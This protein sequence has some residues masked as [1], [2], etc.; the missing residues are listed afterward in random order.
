MNFQWDP[1]P[2]GDLPPGQVTMPQPQTIG[3]EQ[4]AYEFLR[5]LGRGWVRGILAGDARKGDTVQIKRK[6]DFRVKDTA[7]AWSMLPKK[8][9]VTENVRMTEEAIGDAVMPAEW[10]NLP[11]ERFTD[12][13]I[14]EI[15]DRIG[16]KVKQAFPNPNATLVMGVPVVPGFPPGVVGVSFAACDS[17]GG[18]AVRVSK[19][20]A[21]GAKEVN[22][23]FHVV[24]G[25]TGSAIKI[26]DIFQSPNEKE[27]AA[28]E[29][30]KKRLK[31]LLVARAARNVSSKI[32]PF[33]GDLVDWQ[34]R[35][36]EMMQEIIDTAPKAPW[37][38]VP[39]T[40]STIQFKTP[41]HWMP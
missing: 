17:G 15:A 37:V 3:C 24:F 18:I 41:P 6:M 28:L 2:W 19:A 38:S 16:K 29:T 11:L 9:D 10:L 23:R 20:V 5:L 34:R 25:F 32:P 31:E 13:I 35:M 26:A 27:I 40:G 33:E 4:A 7:G 14:R 36:K 21:P 12:K 39:K 22:F 1:L 8:V 30:E